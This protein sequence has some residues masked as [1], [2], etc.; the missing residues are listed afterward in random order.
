MLNQTS[1]KSTMIECYGYIKRTTIIQSKKK[2]NNPKQ[3]RR[4]SGVGRCLVK[5]V[6][7]QGLNL[8]VLV[9]DPKKELLDCNSIRYEGHEAKQ[10]HGHPTLKLKIML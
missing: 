7:Q 2:L 5:V 6:P 8:R 4:E 3:E 1:L 10:W 9:E